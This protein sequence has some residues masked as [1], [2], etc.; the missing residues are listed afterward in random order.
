LRLTIRG[1]T[2]ERELPAT[3]SAAGGDLSAEVV[4]EFRWSEF[5]IEPYSTMFGAIR[6]DERFHLFVSV[7][8][9]RAP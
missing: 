8:A 6:N 9:R 2:V 3:W 4:G 7:F 5:G 1:R